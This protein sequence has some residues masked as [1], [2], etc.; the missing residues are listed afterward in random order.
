MPN[1]SSDTLFH[2]TPKPDYLFQILQHEFKPRYYPEVIRINGHKPI[3]KA[4]PMVCFCDIPLSQIKNHIITYGDYGI[5]MSREW[6]LKN[7]LN[8][9][10]YVQPNSK[11]SASFLSILKTY[12]DVKATRGAS[13]NGIMNVFRYLKNYQGDFRRA[14]KTISNIKFY[15]EKEWRYTPDIIDDI[16][17]WLDN[18]RF[19]D[20]TFLA[21]CNDVVGKSPIS[22][23][24]DDIKYIIIKSENEIPAMITALKRIKSKYPPSVIENLVSRIIT[25]EQI[26]QDF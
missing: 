9:V 15:N 5:G 14:G 13:R 26:K 20:A 19:S 10:V 25:T 17:F 3:T 23:E 11:L 2:F 21:N 22:F 4:I 12:V 1:I 24:P 16:E 6:A 7:K 8:P 18:D